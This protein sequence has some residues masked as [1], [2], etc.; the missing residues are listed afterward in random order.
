LYLA[1]TTDE[2]VHHNARRYS[3]R[4]ANGEEAEVLFMNGG[5]NAQSFRRWE[6]GDDVYGPDEYKK[7]ATDCVLLLRVYLLRSLLT[8]SGC[9]DACG[10]QVSTIR[11]GLLH[12]SEVE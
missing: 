5:Y 9:N 4:I 12:I 10:F 6:A 2:L 7:D 8:R 3:D 1:T 11:L